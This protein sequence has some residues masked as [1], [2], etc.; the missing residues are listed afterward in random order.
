MGRPL[1][2]LDWVLFGGDVTT[3]GPGPAFGGMKALILNES[4]SFCPPAQAARL[5]QSCRVGQHLAQAQGVANQVGW[6]GRVDVKQ[7]IHL[8]V[9]DAGRQD[10]RQIA[11]QL[12]NA[13][14]LRVQG[15]LAR[16]NLG[17]IQNVI[18]Q[19]QQ[20][21]RCVLA[22]GVLDFLGHTLHRQLVSA[23][24]QSFLITPIALNGALV[25]KADWTTTMIKAGDRVEVVRAISGG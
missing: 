5:G 11:Q 22:G 16:F 7:H 10:H 14:R 23:G 21:A 1:A 8:I 24:A 19:A 3:S 15:E 9:V 6:Y 2:A 25:R 17:Q 20:R 12:I 4:L 18:Q 13:K